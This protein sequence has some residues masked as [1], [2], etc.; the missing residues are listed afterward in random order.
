VKV[1]FPEPLAPALM[2]IR[3]SA[4]LLMD[5]DFTGE[6]AFCQD[7][8]GSCCGRASAGALRLHNFADIF[9][10]TLTKIMYEIYSM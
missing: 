3:G 4:A 2:Q 1:V 7:N 9:Q 8:P 10:K 5:R 6:P